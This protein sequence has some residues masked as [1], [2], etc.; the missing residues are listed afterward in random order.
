MHILKL[1][2]PPRIDNRSK[3]KYTNYAHIIDVV[4]TIFQLAVQRY[5]LS[6]E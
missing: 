4:L 2:N 1:A 6:N 5:I 3:L